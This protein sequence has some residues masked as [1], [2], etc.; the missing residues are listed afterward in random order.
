VAWQ[1]DSQKEKDGQALSNL[2]V[3]ANKPN[4]PN[5]Q[6]L[7]PRERFRLGT[8][9]PK[10]AA[11]GNQDRHSNKTRDQKSRIRQ[12]S[13]I[14]RTGEVIKETGLSGAGATE[15]EQHAGGN[16]ATQR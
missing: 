4:K 5:K 6:L 13:R 1:N 16:G 12:E 9:A 15:K 3:W 14:P 8:S 10:Q 7:N 11:R 2:P